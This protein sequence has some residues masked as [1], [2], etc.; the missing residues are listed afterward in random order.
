M[1]PNVKVAGGIFQVGSD[2]APAGCKIVCRH[3]IQVRAIR[4]GGTVHMFAFRRQSGTDG[5]MAAP[6]NGPKDE[7]RRPVDGKWAEIYQDFVNIFWFL[8]DDLSF[9]EL[10]TVFTAPMQLKREK[11]K[12]IRA[13]FFRENLGRK[14]FFFL[15]L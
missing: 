6:P 9:V 12:S 8:S 10:H 3:R 15:S 5:A 7:E 2:W 13:F 1:F 4:I 11:N 14:E